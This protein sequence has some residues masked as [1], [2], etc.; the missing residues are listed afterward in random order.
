MKIFK[1]KTVFKNKFF[2]FSSTFK[3]EDTKIIKAT[4]FYDKPDYTK[5]IVFGLH[6]SDYMLEIDHN[7]KDG[8]SAPVINPYHKF[9]LDPRNQTLHYGIELFEGMKAFRNGKKVYLYRPELNMKRMNS[10]A[11]RVGLPAF[12]GE[13]LIKCIVKIIKLEES[14]VRDERG[15]SLYIRPTFISMADVLGVQP[16]THSKLFVILSPVGPYFASGMKPIRLLCNNPDY[17]RA[18]PGGFGCYK[19]GA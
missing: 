14:W 13:E 3:A 12:D 5:P 1:N 8:W 11:K 4:K 6:H 18:Y 17:L 19:L 10:S 2:S 7:I 15:F 9:E 16:P